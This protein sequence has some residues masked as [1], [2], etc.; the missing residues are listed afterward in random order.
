MPPCVDLRYGQAVE[1]TDQSDQREQSRFVVNTSIAALLLAGLWWWWVDDAVAPPEQELVHAREEKPD[2]DPPTLSEG[3]LEREVVGDGKVV[4]VLPERPEDADLSHPYSFRLTVSLKGPFGLAVDDAN[5]FL[6]PDFSGFSMWPEPT[7]N[8]GHVT[9]NWRGRQPAMSVQVGVMAWGVLQPMRRVTVDADTPTRIAFA[10]RGRE[11]DLSALARLAEKSSSE[12]RRDQRGVQRERRRSRKRIRMDRLDMVCGR[13]M[14]MFRK[15][16]CLECHEKG[17][18]TAYRAIARSTKMKP[19][20]HPEARFEDLTKRGLSGGELSKR[21]KELAKLLREKKVEELE[22]AA[23]YRAELN[24]VVHGANGK[25]APGVPVAWVDANGAVAKVTSTDSVGRYSLEHVPGGNLRMIVGGGPLGHAEALVRVAPTGTTIWNATLRFKQ[26][27]FGKVLDEKGKPLSRWP[28][29]LVRNADGWAT[30]AITNRDGEFATYDAPGTAQ[31]VVWPRD[32]TSSFPVIYGKEAMVDASTLTLKLDNDFPI[33]GRLRVTVETPSGYE[34]S[35][36]NARVVQVESGRVAEMTPSGF[37]GE[38]EAE[39]LS[40]GW[41]ELQLGAAGL[42][43]VERRIFVDGRGLWDVGTVH[44]GAPGR[45]RIHR[46]PGAP[47]VTRAPHAFYRRTDA[48]DILVE[49]ARR[50]NSYELA[51]GPHVFVWKSEA[52]LRAREIQVVSG[53]ETE[54]TIWPE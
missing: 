40:P 38:F 32:A 13:T 35:L 14:L 10:V 28:V 4:E 18:V 36:I 21:K 54:L 8:G 45:V 7:K 31:C 50:Y 52:G 34:R 15:F 49:A 43:W 42:G 22:E 25:P 9:L 53:K 46:L 24:G 41:Y 6:A 30:L 11:Q 44:L 29:E 19:G 20:L 3:D 16:H 12:D 1:R 51:P 37:G 39:P 23:N 48:T 17:R 5:V 33:R 26:S 27:I 2:R 47:D